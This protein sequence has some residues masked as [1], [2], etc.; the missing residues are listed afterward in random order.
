M[1][2][3]T[4]DYFVQFSLLSYLH[5][6]V[7][8]FRSFF[9]RFLSLLW[10]DTGNNWSFAAQFKFQFFI[11]SIVSTTHTKKIDWSSY[12]PHAIVFGY[13]DEETLFYSITLQMNLSI[14]ALFLYYIFLS[15]LR[16]CR[17]LCHPLCILSCPNIIIISGVG[18][19]FA[20]LLSYRETVLRLRLMWRVWCC[21]VLH[22]I[23]SIEGD[24]DKNVNDVFICGTR[25][26]VI[27]KMQHWWNLWR[28]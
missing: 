15:S 13:G 27:L 4:F 20:S 23:N 25:I 5:I 11:I 12:E 2:L 17:L 8:A 14:S 3:L 16:C 28:H 10:V 21:A 26:I 19:L 9:F 18:L 22:A 7:N 1:K 6:S 24:F